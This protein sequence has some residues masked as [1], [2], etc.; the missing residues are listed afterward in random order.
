MSANEDAVA[1]LLARITGICRTFA[2]KGFFW[3]RRGSE[4]SFQG[5]IPKWHAGLFS[6]L[7][8]RVQD[9]Q[10]VEPYGA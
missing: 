6:Q 1:V 8:A 10:W 2:F 7:L 5:F 3:G 4:D 9:S